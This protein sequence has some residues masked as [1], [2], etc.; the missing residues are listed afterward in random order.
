MCVK[1]LS[2]RLAPQGCGW[3]ACSL[4]VMAIRWWL[5]LS[6][7]PGREGGWYEMFTPSRYLSFVPS[8]P[9]PL[10]CPRDWTWF[11]WVKSEGREWK[12]W[13]TELSPSPP[14]WPRDDADGF[15]LYHIM[16]WTRGPRAS[17]SWTWSWTGGCEALTLPILTR[18]SLSQPCPCRTGPALTPLPPWCRMKP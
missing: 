8:T 18:V 4:E 6:E 5:L 12:T 2:A 9:S 7:D 13:E 10:S 11:A 14:W 15:C 3:E 1:L 16:S 17:I